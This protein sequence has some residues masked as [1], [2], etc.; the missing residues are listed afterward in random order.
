MK[1]EI[2]FIISQCVNFDQVSQLLIV[3]DTFDFFDRM[4]LLF[5]LSYSQLAFFLYDT[6]VLRLLELS[7]ELGIRRFQLALAHFA[8]LIH[9]A[10]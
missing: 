4:T 6:G 1:R 8:F 2:C 3:L 10:L 5:G 7:V 9:L